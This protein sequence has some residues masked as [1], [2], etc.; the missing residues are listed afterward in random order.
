MD[1]SFYSE[2][3]L[4][5]IPFRRLL[6]EVLVNYPTF[7]KN[8]LEKCYNKAVELHS[9]QL[10]LS[11]EPYVNHVIKVALLCCEFKLDF[12]SVCAALLHD[13]LE[14][15][16][17]TKEAL[18]T[19]FGLEIASL[20]EAVTK[21]S[22]ISL[23]TKEERQAENFR[24]LLLAMA[25]DI[26]V[27]LIKLCDRLHNM[28]T[29]DSLPELK[30]KKIAEETQE[31]YVPLANRLGL[32]R[33]KALLEDYSLKELKPA[34]YQEIKQKIETLAKDL[35][36]FAKEFSE[37]LKVCLEKSGISAQISFRLK[38][39]ASIYQKM[40]RYNCT[41]EQVMDILGFRVIVPTILACYEALGIIHSKY[42]LVPG[43]IKDYIAMPKPN[44]Y[45]SLHTTVLTQNGRRVEIQ[46]RTPEMHQLA[47]QGVAAHWRYKDTSK[48]DFDLSWVRDLVETQKYI[49][50]PEEF[51]Q[52]VKSELFHSEIYV[53]S[54]KGDLF[55]L[56]RGATPL[57]FA[58]AVHT[59]I[60]HTTV[61]A[62]VNGSIVPL[63][64]KLRNGDSVEII[65]QKG[66][67][68]SKD[69]L[70]IVVTSKAKNRIKQFIRQERRELAVKAGRELLSKD[71]AKQGISLKKI[72]KT[73]EFKQFLSE[74][75]VKSD[76]ELYAN[77]Y[78]GKISPSRVALKFASAESEEQPIEEQK[79]I[80][81][82]LFDSVAKSSQQ[83]GIKVSGFSD[84]FFRFAKCCQPLP[85][86]RIIGYVTKGKGLTIHSIKCPEIQH[87]DPLRFVPVQW[88]SGS[89]NGLR[90][91]NLEIECLN[92]IGML[93]KLCSVITELGINI[94]SASAI[95][96]PDNSAKISFEIQV[97]DTDELEAAKR[98][99]E[100]TKG[101]SR[102][103]RV[104]YK[105]STN[106]N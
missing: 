8:L 52:S 18:K 106:F 80:I 25:S 82:K 7:D 44:M 103:V 75:G 23:A 78:Y 73:N 38:H 67:K 11:G 56:P 70:K 89:L 76:E 93:S 12:T 43:R 27:I 32:Y 72:E 10:R 81:S 69:W 2:K 57:D 34:D 51:L 59:E 46:I 31:I 1:E 48:F 96:F 84:V 87:L 54:P 47:E 22:K 98:K 85:G 5:V 83:S 92:E 63:H 99:L 40:V 9:T 26:R 37:E 71:L 95:T 20:V 28:M 62:R 33:L 79:G 86:D 55:R 64:Y 61:G 88:E 66:H 19:E 14:D 30:R 102:V 13:T 74:L 60:G 41:F 91:V 50:N 58:Y 24:K 39:I 16:V 90:S 17:Y 105:K 94:A 101:V 36:V 21:L 53:F 77:L 4:E 45:Q 65:T 29:L 104:F 35:N 42:Q 6:D 49:T 97:H 15:T 68:P 100:Q 3:S